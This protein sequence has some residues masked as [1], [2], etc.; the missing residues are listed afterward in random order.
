M[1]GARRIPGVG[2]AADRL[3]K[4]LLIQLFRVQSEVLFTRR[5]LS[6]MVVATLFSSL[7][8]IS[9]L[10]AAY[11]LDWPPGATIALTAALSYLVLL[12]SKKK[13]S[14]SLRST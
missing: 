8:S 12:F 9:G 14:R 7:F 2:I 3:I 11:A 5:L 4:L 1:P 10:S 13:L 6:M